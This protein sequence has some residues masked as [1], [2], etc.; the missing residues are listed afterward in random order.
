MAPDSSDKYDKFLMFLDAFNIP[1][2]NLVDTPPVVP[3]REEE[4]RGLLRQLGKIT[5]VYATTTMPKISVVLRE[6]YAGAGT[7]LQCI[8]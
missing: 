7:E 2:I 3:D 5:D 1:L 6:A 8:F 4:A